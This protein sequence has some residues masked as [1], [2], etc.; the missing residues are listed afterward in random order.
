MR[1]KSHGKRRPDHSNNSKDPSA[2]QLIVAFQ[3]GDGIRG[4]AGSTGISVTLVA[5]NQPGH[6]VF[7]CPIASHP[8]DESAPAVAL[9]RSGP[10]GKI[11]GQARGE[12]RIGNGGS[13]ST[14]PILCGILGQHAH[15]LGADTLQ[16]TIVDDR[17]ILAK[18]TV[19][20]RMVY[21]PDNKAH[22]WDYQPPIFNE[23]GYPNLIDSPWGPRFARSHRYGYS[24]KYNAED[25]K[26]PAPGSATSRA[27]MWSAADII[28]YLR[29]VHY[30]RSGS[31]RPTMS[32]DVGNYTLP[33]YIQW[34]KGLGKTV[35]YER[36]IQHFNL[37]GQSL[38]DALQMV[39]A[40]VGW[41]LYVKAIG[42][43]QSEIT[44]VNF[45]VTPD[46]A[47]RLFL[48]SY[49]I[50]DIG[51]AMSASD[52]IHSGTLVENFLNRSKAVAII[53]DPPVVERFHSTD[54][55]GTGALYLEP[56]WSPDET[57][58]K[59]YIDSHHH[60]AEAY[61]AACEIWPLVYTA[62]RVKRWADI[63]ANTKWSGTANIP[64]PRIHPTQLTG[65]NQDSSSVHR[66]LGCR[67]RSSSSK[68][69]R[70]TKRP[71]STPSPMATAGIPTPAR[72]LGLRATSS[73][74][75]T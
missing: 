70:R 27:R 14:V 35:G 64:Y 48:P 54:Y 72:N 41:D 44:F 4:A 25:T 73:T 16:S 42:G 36:T 26:T 65:F 37:H 71:H 63:W 5:G 66:N 23:L 7:S 56:A 33:S 28:E 50:N 8:V 13:G 46:Q 52:L 59:L 12:F 58:F 11:K 55:T 53:S 49:G 1:M 20:S 22:Y 21:D 40:H 47:G 2:Q 17:A 69:C 68:R 19:H 34:P 67:V 24:S 29:D 62:Y 51:E 31:V 60:D 30:A 6:G 57:L 61:N 39:G 74:A 3:S 43:F 9:M 15:N 38:L 10:A 75:C 45:R 32:V 18:Y